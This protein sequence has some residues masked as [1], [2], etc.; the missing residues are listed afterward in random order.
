MDIE[1]LVEMASL[2][3]NAKRTGAGQ[4]TLGYLYDILRLADPNMPIRWDTGAH[5]GNKP[6]S[7]HQD[8][9]FSSEFYSQ[10]P[11]WSANSDSAAP[12]CYRGYYMDC[13]FNCS[14]FFAE[15]TVGH[16]LDM[17]HHT[18]DKTFSGYKGGEYTFTNGTAVWGGIT[19]WD[20]TG[21]GAMLTGFEII[22]SAIVLQTAVEEW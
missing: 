22:D 18:L 20:S 9:G 3:G 1:K 6:I 16:V 19:S 14:V 15:S 4:Q 7:W 2:A 10:G 17:V 13:T 12:S 11:T 5:F 21:D 8:E